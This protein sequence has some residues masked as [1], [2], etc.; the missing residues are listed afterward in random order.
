ME[1][2][3]SARGQAILSPQDRPWDRPGFDL[4]RAQASL[5]W[6]RVASGGWLL[7]FL[8]YPLR[9]LWVCQGLLDTFLKLGKLHWFLYLMVSY[10]Y[11]PTCNMFIYRGLHKDYSLSRLFIPKARWFCL[12]E[13][14]APHMCFPKTIAFISQWIDLLKKAREVHLIHKAKTIE[15]LGMNKRDK[16]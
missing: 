1:W 3:Y 5:A 2:F 13:W 7:A 10:F 9:D 14:G 8:D 16:E 12:Y 11:N 6:P 15:P 4:Y